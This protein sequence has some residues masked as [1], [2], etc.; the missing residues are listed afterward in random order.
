MNKHTH[1]EYLLYKVPHE[2]DIKLEAKPQ[3]TKQIT[4]YSKGRYTDT[5]N[6]N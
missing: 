3:I 5:W 4:F 6:M 1:T 2:T